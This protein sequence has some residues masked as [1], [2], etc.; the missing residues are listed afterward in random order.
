MMRVTYFLVFAALAIAPARLRSQTPAPVERWGVFETA[1]KGP[2][3]GNPFVEVN[4]AASFR[5]GHRVVEA[6]GFYDGSGTYRVRFMP[7]SLGEW[8]YVTKSNRRELDGKSGKFTC[9]PNSP[10]NHGP[11]R[12]R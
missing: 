7:D 12:V 3:A 11:V 9:V 8:S 6:E 1:F 4:F 2:E 5:L 10:S